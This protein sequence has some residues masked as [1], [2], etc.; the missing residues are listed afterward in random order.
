MKDLAQ[1][2]PQNPLLL[3]KDLKAS[4]AGNVAYIMARP[5]NLYVRPISPSM[6]YCLL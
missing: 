1:R 3:L 6:K 4:T 2:F 5:M